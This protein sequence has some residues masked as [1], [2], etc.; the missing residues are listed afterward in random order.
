[1]SS[2]AD[3]LLG[4]DNNSDDE[5][6]RTDDIEE[7]KKVQLLDSDDDYSDEEIERIKQQYEA[8]KPQLRLEESLALDD[9][10]SLAE[11]SEKV[12]K[13]I[14]KSGIVYISRI[15]PYMKPTKLRHILSR[16]GEVDRI[17]LAPED[18]KA[19]KARVKNG[20]NK[21]KSY[22]EGWAE[23]TRKKD[24]K[25]AA[26]A[27]N[28]N[29]IGGKKSS[30]Y[31]DDILNV[32]YL[33]KF[34]WHHLTEQTA[35]EARVRQARLRSEVAQATKLNKTFIAN[36]EKAK[37]VEAIKKKKRARENNN[38]SDEKDE[39]RMDTS[40]P[41]AKR[42]FTQKTVTTSEAKSSTIDKIKSVLGRIF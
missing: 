33:H 19:Y 40:E 22:S 13:K 17:Y 36:V 42:Q 7:T 9:S 2:K 12:R 3:E 27:L 11:E 30:F 28:G 37:E 14:A 1:M 26:L 34:K 10:K 38:D 8:L 18:P 16:F 39:P 29:I 21:K 41:P 20:G 35:Y 24:A 6:M 32:K 23:F 31:H 15:P 5:F 25:T 4:I